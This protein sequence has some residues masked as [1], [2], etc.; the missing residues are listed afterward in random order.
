MLLL[1]TNHAEYEV[2]D[3]HGDSTLHRAVQANQNGLLRPY[4]EYTTMDH[5][6]EKFKRVL[7][8]RNKS[9]NGTVWQAAD[10]RGRAEWTDLVKKYGG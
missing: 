8:H 3:V 9:M 1:K 6:Q 7:T 10:A 5:D 2:Y 4:L